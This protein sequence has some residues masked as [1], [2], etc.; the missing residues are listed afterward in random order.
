MI[1]FE[2]C[3]LVV[4]VAFSIGYFGSWFSQD[5]IATA[6]GIFQFHVAIVLLSFA[7]VLRCADILCFSFQGIPRHT[8]QQPGIQQQAMLSIYPLVI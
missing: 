8:H 6:L 2:S 1:I 7:S 4:S 3:Y 5:V